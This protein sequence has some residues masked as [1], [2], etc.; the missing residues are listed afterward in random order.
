M[1][2]RNYAFDKR[3]KDLKKKQKH[4]DKLRRRLERR[5]DRAKDDPEGGAESQEAE[6]PEGTDGSP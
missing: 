5:A 2:K 4:E 1:P 6:L 3:Q